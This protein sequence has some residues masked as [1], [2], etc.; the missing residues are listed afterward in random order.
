LQKKGIY[1][2][3]ARP[4]QNSPAPTAA[5]VDP[6]IV[7]ELSDM[8][9]GIVNECGIRHVEALARKSAQGNQQF[10][11][12]CGEAVAMS[13]REQTTLRECA[14]KLAEKYKISAQYGVET[15]AALTLATYGWRW[16]RTERTLVKMLAA[17]QQ[18]TTPTPTPKAE[19]AT[20]P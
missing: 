16:Y 2:G 18:T 13:D 11:R 9:I 19:N 4:R 15:L 17:Q 5:T 14:A 12:E 7:K 6:E 20:Q 1:S 3:N 8:L 10:V